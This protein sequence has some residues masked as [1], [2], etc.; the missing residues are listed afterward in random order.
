MKIDELGI[1]GAISWT[2]RIQNIR[3]NSNLYPHQSRITFYT[4]PWETLYI[5]SFSLLQVTPDELRTLIAKYNN[6]DAMA[7][8]GITIA[9][10]KYMYLSSNDKVIRA[11]KGMNGVHTIKTT[12]SK[13]QSGIS[14]PKSKWACQFV[15]LGPKP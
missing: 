15:S 5:L 4:L 10:I 2:R 14:K 1:N 7:T 8:S 6:V 13:F 12:Q 11:K 3:K 9:G